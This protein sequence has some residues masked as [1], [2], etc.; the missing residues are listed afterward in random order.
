[1]GRLEDI[2]AQVA[3]LT[4]ERVATAEESALRD[5][6]LERLDLLRRGEQMKDEKN[7][8]QSS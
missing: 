3:A 1:M 8:L 6:E 7:P 4:G 5:A 2:E